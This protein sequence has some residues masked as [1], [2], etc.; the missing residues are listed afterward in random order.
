MPHKHTSWSCNRCLKRF[1]SYDEAHGCE[2][3]HITSEAAKN[4]SDDLDGIM[5]ANRRALTEKQP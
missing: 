3:Q 2:L 1:R 5:R 4:F